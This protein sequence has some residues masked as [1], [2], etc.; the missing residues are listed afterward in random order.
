M[1]TADY[2]LRVERKLGLGRD[3]CA[4]PSHRRKLT[5]V[6]SLQ[7]FRRVIKVSAES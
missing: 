7:F 2:G 6:R 1:V 3:T 4:F 5:T